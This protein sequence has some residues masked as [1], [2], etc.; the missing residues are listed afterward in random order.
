MRGNRRTKNT[1]VAVESR[2]LTEFYAWRIPAANPRFPP[3]T[4]RSLAASCPTIRRLFHHSRCPP[5]DVEIRIR[6]CW[7]EQRRGR[8]STTNV[9]G[10]LAAVRKARFTPAVKCE[11]CN[12]S[13]ETPTPGLLSLPPS[14][15][16]T[17]NREG[18]QREEILATFYGRWHP[19][20]SLTTGK[21]HPTPVIYVTTNDL[22]IVR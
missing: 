10:N 9:D 17:E 2:S 4:G 18:E 3:T 22:P 6:E 13:I 5:T 12:E 14:P 8:Q 20:A 19:S 11:N 7:W 15:C 1:F 16:P 21:V